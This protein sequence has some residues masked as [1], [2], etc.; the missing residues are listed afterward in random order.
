MQSKVIGQANQT[1]FV[2]PPYL[3]PPQLDFTFILCVC[4]CSG[5]HV[6]VVQVQWLQ[7]PEGDVGSTST[8]VVIFV[9]HYVGAENEPGASER[10]ANAFNHRV[11]SPDPLL[12]VRTCVCACFCRPQTD[13]KCL[14]GLSLNLALTNSATLADQHRPPTPTR[15]STALRLQACSHHHALFFTLS[16]GKLNSAPQVCT[17]SILPTKSLFQPLLLVAWLN[18]SQGLE[19]SVTSL[20]LHTSL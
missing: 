15:P 3:P 20:H 13:D 1:D 16:A 8:G 12:W 6:T 5:V 11:I 4:V 14:L 9:G 19:T 2:P 17:A 7:R 10:A 18:F